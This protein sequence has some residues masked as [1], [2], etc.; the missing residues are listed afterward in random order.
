MKKIEIMNGLSR[1]FN[2]ANLQ[3]KKHAPEIM[4][5]AG[6][7]GMVASAIMACK[8]T[9]KVSGILE[10]TKEQ[11]DGVHQVLA[12]EN[13]PAERYSE[14]DS[15]KDLAIIYAHAGIKFVKLYGPSVVLGALSIAS[16][17]TSNHIHRKRNVAL[18]AAYTVV[19]KGFKDYRSRVVERFGKE[20][21][22]ELRYNIKADKIEEVVVNEKGEEKTVEKTVEVADPTLLYSDYARCYDCGNK[23]WTDSSEANLTYLRQV[24]RYMNDK[25]RLRGHVFLNEVYDELGIPR[26]EAGQVVGWYYDE[27]NP[28]GDNFIDFG[29]YDLYKEGS[30]DFV[31]GYEKAIWL[32]FN[33]DGP[34]LNLLK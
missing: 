31:N 15:K 26:S 29:I 16:I 14:E 3:L 5:V 17:L 18:A 28:H 23:G 9:T 4:V 8:A 21:D 33:V 25:L 1:T 24:Q 7:V 10:E 13:V 19:D 34:I 2:R 22:R 6:V 11:I 20:L 32:D 30:R 12:D 27:K